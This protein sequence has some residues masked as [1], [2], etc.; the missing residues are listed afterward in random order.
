MIEASTDVDNL[1]QELDLVLSCR[2]GAVSLDVN[3]HGTG[4]KISQW[5]RN[6]SVA[7]ADEAS[8]TEVDPYLWWNGFG[9]CWHE[10]L[11]VHGAAHVSKLVI[12]GGHEVMICADSSGEVIRPALCGPDPRMEPD[13]K[14]LLSQLPGGASDWERI[15]GLVPS[16]AHLVSK[17]S[18]LHRSEPENWARIARLTPLSAWIGSQLTGAEPVITAAVAQG[19]GLWSPVEGAYSRLICQIIDADRDLRNFLPKVAIAS[20]TEVGDTALIGEWNGI[21]VVSS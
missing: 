7:G 4:A 16:S 13:A 8:L 6:W 10:A 2:A 9:E 18:W 3:D 1:P 5:E 15:T 14:W 20:E 11:S 12:Q 21:T 19:T 17:C